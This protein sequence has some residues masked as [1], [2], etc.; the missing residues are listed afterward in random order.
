MEFKSICCYRKE[1]RD[2]I[3]ADLRWISVVGNLALEKGERIAKGKRISG[4]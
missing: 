3:G 4:K 1:K 2:V